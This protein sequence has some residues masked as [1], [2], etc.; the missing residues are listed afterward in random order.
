MKRSILYIEHAIQEEEL[1]L[2]VNNLGIFRKGSAF[3]SVRN[4][5]GLCL[6]S[7]CHVLVPSLR[8]MRQFAP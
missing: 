1:L 5:E 3:R 6:L 7:L 4:M 2:A 8:E